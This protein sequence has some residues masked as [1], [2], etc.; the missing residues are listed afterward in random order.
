MKNGQQEFDA[1]RFS[2][3]RY[4]E[5]LFRKVLI[6]NTELQV[7]KIP[8]LLTPLLQLPTF[9]LCYLASYFLNLLSSVIPQYARHRPHYSEALPQ[10]LVFPCTYL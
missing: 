2:S 6:A 8:D 3:D 4:S 7:V 1:C 5:G 9:S 10:L